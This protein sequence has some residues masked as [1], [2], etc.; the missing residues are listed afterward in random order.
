MQS[1]FR[2][3]GID[4]IQITL[5]HFATLSSPHS[6]LPSRLEEH[7]GWQREERGER[8]EREEREERGERGRDRR[9]EGGGRGKGTGEGW[10]ALASVLETVE[11]V[12]RSL[13]NLEEKLHHAQHVYAMLSPAC[14]VP[15]GPVLAG[16]ALLS[17]GLLA[18][19]YG[20]WKA[21]TNTQRHAQ[22]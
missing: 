20:P 2:V 11:L 10:V 12:L 4:A 5:P 19:G 13:N 1:P 16:P 17:V 21:W 14:F 7:K 22:G 6:P 9:E 15:A 18:L 3:Y 8:E